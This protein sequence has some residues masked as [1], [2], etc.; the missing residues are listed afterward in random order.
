[1]NK[2]IIGILLVIIGL[3]E[4]FLIIYTFKCETLSHGPNHPCADN[5]TFI[6][7]SDIT[8]AILGIVL[9]IAGIYFFSKRG[10]LKA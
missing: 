9:A 3:L 1:M 6:A 8:P 2:K 7:L 5:K 10:T 4:V